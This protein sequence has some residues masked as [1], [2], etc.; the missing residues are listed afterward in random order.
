MDKGSRSGGGR[1]VVPY[2]TTGQSGACQF[3]TAVKFSACEFCQVT[4]IPRTCLLDQVMTISFDTKTHQSLSNLSSYIQDVKSFII[5]DCVFRGGFPYR[6]ISYNNISCI[7]TSGFPSPVCCSH[8]GHVGE[9]RAA[10]DA[11]PAPRPQGDPRP[12]LALG[13]PGTQFNIKQSCL[14]FGFYSKIFLSSRLLR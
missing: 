3:A 11:D 12:R 5:Q 6:C 1:N 13:R 4:V 14:I 2:V 9:G 8:P 7:I 10:A